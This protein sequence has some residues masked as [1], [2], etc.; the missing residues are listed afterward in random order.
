MKDFIL[1]AK[2]EYLKWNQSIKTALAKAITYKIDFLLL[3]IAPLLLFFFI[4]YNLWTSI[5]HIN[6]TPSIGGYTLEKMI[7]YQIWILI[8]DLFVK[9]QFF[10]ENL[11]ESIR[12]GRI[13]AA[14]LY[15]F[16][17]IKQNLAV[18]ISDKI[19][20]FFS[21]SLIFMFCLSFDFL[22]LPSATILLK[23]LLFIIAVNGFWFLSQTIIGLLAFWLEETWSLNVCVR[24]IVIF[25]SG[26]LLPL[27][28]YPDLLQQIL[29]WTP[30]PYLAYFPVKILMQEESLSFLFGLFVLCFWILVLSFLVRWLWDKGLKL[31]TGSGI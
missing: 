25:F 26:S 31:Y 3:T 1:S 27:E 13:S 22:H 20:Q 28:L 11:S 29:K 15:P 17:F 12:L 19:L 7:S 10:S 16:S 24:F 21:A 23:A 6:K 9:V 30:F 18:F 4:K 2:W 14:L 8:F 5:Y